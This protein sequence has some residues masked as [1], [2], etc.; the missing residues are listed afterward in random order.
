MSFH[1][2]ERTSGHAGP[3]DLVEQ[4]ANKANVHVHLTVVVRVAL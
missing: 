2:R 1:T 4:Y 3:R